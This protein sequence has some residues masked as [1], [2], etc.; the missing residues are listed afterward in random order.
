[1]PTRRRH[2]ARPHSRHALLPRYDS[3]KLSIR[4]R[5]IPPYPMREPE[6]VT[7]VNWLNAQVLMGVTSKAH[8]TLLIIAYVD[9]GTIPATSID[10]LIKHPSMPR[11]VGRLEMEVRLRTSAV[12]RVIHVTYVSGYSYLNVVGED[13]N[14]VGHA[15]VAVA[16]LLS[17][18]QIRFAWARKG[19]VT[20]LLTAISL[21]FFLASLLTPSIVR[22]RGAHALVRDLNVLGYAFLILMSVV[23]ISCPSPLTVRPSR[24][25]MNRQRDVVVGI[26]IVAV[27]VVL[28]LVSKTND[29]NTANKLTIVA[30]IVAVLIGV[31]PFYIVNR[32]P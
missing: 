32:R 18:R 31:L 4:Y 5:P 11:T 6:L 24:W 23:T 9:G 7:I 22:G 26:V 3:K 30:I 8:P 19:S 20:L 1:M 14:W 2:I 17:K 29:A 10:H 16:A 21:F 28:Y 27:G 13:R 15:Y 12:H 25:W